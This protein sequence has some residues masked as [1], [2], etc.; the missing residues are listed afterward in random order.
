VST[1]DR[2]GTLGVLSGE[3]VCIGMA[4]LAINPILTKRHCRQLP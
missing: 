2:E 4:H 1:N 3:S